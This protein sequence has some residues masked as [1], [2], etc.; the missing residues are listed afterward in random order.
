MVRIK[1]YDDSDYQYPIIV[2]RDEAEEQFKKDLD[3][4]RK[5]NEGDYT[6]EEFIELIETKEYFIDYINYDIRVYF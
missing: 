3:D 2:V 4:Y 5:E 6:I 1:L